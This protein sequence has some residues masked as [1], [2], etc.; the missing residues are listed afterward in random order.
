MFDFLERV[1]KKPERK[2]R[3]YAVSFSL[4]ITAVIFVVWLSTILPTSISSEA[5][6]GDGSWKKQIVSPLGAVKRNTAQAFDALRGQLDSITEAIKA[7]TSVYNAAD[8]TNSPTKADSA[9]ST[10]THKK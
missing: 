4:G 2:R 3:M 7:N 10:K 8:A 5:A 6:N 1:Y 9:T